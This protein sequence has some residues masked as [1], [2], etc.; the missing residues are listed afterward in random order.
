MAPLKL[1]EDGIRR[2]PLAWLAVVEQQHSS[3]G[4]GAQGGEDGEAEG[5]ADG[6]SGSGSGGPSEAYVVACPAC[7]ADVAP[8]ALAHAWQQL[9]VGSG[10]G[11]L[12]HGGRSA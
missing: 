3:S 7:R 2:Q 10:T 1:Q 5:E 8:S 4:D 6:G 11:R 9:Q 12:L